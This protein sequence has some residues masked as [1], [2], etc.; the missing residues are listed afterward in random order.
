MEGMSQSRWAL[1]HFF[2]LCS[3]KPRNREGEEEG[4]TDQAAV[5]CHLYMGKRRPRERKGYPGGGGARS[6]L[7]E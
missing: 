2:T 1:P 3:E 6:E 7:V 5:P 4:L